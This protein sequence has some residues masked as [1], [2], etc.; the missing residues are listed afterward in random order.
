MYYTIF[1]YLAIK[2]SQRFQSCSCIISIEDFLVFQF[3]LK[4]KYFLITQIFYNIKF[5][6]YVC[7][8]CEVQIKPQ[9]CQRLKYFS[10]QIACII[11]SDLTL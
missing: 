11:I 6:R 1:K 2:F 8:M 4:I 5:G 7:I 9:K 3:S 10:F